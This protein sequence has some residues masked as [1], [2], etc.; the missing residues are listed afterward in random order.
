MK[1]MLYM[2]LSWQL[3][4]RVELIIQLIIQLNVFVFLCDTLYHIYEIYTP[5]ILCKHTKSMTVILASQVKL[6]IVYFVNNI[7]YCS[8]VTYG[9]HK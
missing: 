5:A 3:R 6:I 7:N 1:H 9:L 2:A 8:D 4:D